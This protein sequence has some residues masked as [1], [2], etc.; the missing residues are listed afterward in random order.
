MVTKFIDAKG[1]SALIFDG[2][3]GGSILFS[4]SFTLGSMYCVTL[5][6]K[7]C[8]VRTTSDFFFL[9]S[10]HYLQCLRSGYSKFQLNQTSSFEFIALDS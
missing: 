1:I 7:I 2:L 6:A 10:R 4:L 8:I 3:C 9:F 5:S